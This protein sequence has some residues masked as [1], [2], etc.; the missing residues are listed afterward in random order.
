MMFGSHLTVAAAGFAV[1]LRAVAGEPTAWPLDLSLLAAFALVMLGA[2]LPDIDHPESTVGRR[3][4]WLS[5]P[6]R[7]VFGHRGITHSI[8]AVFGMMWLA[9]VYGNVWLSWLA[10]GYLLHLVGDYLT[11]S[12]IPLLYPFSRARYKFL[13]TGSTNGISEPLIVGA[14]LVCSAFFVFM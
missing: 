11:D 14:V 3:V 6:I 7:L 13:I 8:V 10:L 4:K 9:F 1:Y 2:A 12:G 5:H